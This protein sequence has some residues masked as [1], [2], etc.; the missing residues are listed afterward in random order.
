MVIVKNELNSKNICLRSLD[1]KDL[2]RVLGWL[3]DP[4][5]NM[6][7]SQDFK[8]L[9]IQKEKEWLAYI[10]GSARDV[11]F[12]IVYR[13]SNTHIGNCGIHKIDHAA[14]SCELGIF[15]GEK[16][17]WNKGY[18]SEA[19]DLIKDY[20]FYILK[21]SKIYLNVYEYNNRAIKVYNK[22]GFVIKKTIVKDHL[23][24]GK[25]WDTYHMEIYKD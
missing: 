25:Y 6:F 12:A 22:C 19:V 17:Y 24:N 4:R 20:V 8:D 2:K 13:D 7:L 3:K 18:G 16:G 15:I 11:V 1:E 10:N 9:T 14:G 21:I 5:V 23:Y